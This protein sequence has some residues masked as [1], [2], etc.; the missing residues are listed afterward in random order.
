M[1]DTLTEVFSL[2]D[3][4]SARCTR[5]EAGGDW[6]LR[7][8]AKPALK[9]AAVM[10]GGCW[11]IYPNQEHI[12]LD[13]GDVFLLSHTPPYVI[14]SDP[15]LLAEDGVAVIDWEHSD[16]G[17]YGGAETVLLVGSFLLDD[18]H[19]Q[20]LIDTLPPFMRIPAAA[21]S[22]AS[23][24]HTLEILDTEIRRTE[25]GFGLMRRHLADMLLVQ[26][27]RAFA[28]R[29]Y[30]GTTAEPEDVLT[31]WIGALNN[32]QIGAAL[33]LM[34][35]EPSRPWT[36]A[37]LSHRVGMSRSSFSNAFRT[38]VGKSP[39]DY[40]LHWRMQLAQRLIQEGLSIAEVSETVGYMSQSAF[41][42]AFKRTVG[43]S[44]KAQLK[45]PVGKEENR[46]R[47]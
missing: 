36:V 12:W 25:I 7:F 15:N 6:A 1:S 30:A 17:H 19:A 8:P 43:H 31:S 27:L 24:R 2:L 29:E 3:L 22:A 10:R 37:D 46:Q 39:I 45:K 9:F 35:S 5:L 14:A 13:E 28:K 4:R 34:H 21:P 26:L 38:A 44:P 40:L 33:D 32:S 47:R 42:A 20:L 16:T 18:L 23:L 11:L 41:G